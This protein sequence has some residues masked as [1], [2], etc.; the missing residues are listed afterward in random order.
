M[1]GRRRSRSYTRSTGLRPGT[2]SRWATLEWPAGSQD[3]DAAPAALARYQGTDGSRVTSDY[4]PFPSSDTNALCADCHKTQ[5]GMRR[6]VDAGPPTEVELAPPFN[7]SKLVP[8]PHGR[9]IEEGLAE[10]VD[11]HMANTRTSIN[12]N[13]QRSHAM[14][15]NEQS[16]GGYSHYDSSC[17][18]SNCHDGSLSSVPD[19]TDCVFCHSEFGL[20][21]IDSFEAVRRGRTLLAPEDSPRTGGRRPGGS[22]R[23]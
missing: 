22:E 3:P 7:S 2:H 15:P 14:V 17:G 18:A 20:A 16:L 11:C 13:D 19:F 1:S 8:V 12:S 5:V 21:G 9:H 4:L 23:R 10:C 6:H